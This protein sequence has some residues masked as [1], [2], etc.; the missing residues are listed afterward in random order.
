M[1]TCA[2]RT[3]VTRT[4]PVASATRPGRG[5]TASH[6]LAALALFGATAACS[7]VQHV[8]LRDDYATTD[9]LSTVRIAVVVAPLPGGREDLGQLWATLA[10]RYANQH[11]DFLARPAL[12]AASL[13]AEACAAPRQGVLHLLPT[14]RVDGD[15]VAVTVTASLRRCADDVQIWQAS[16]KGSWA[17]ADDE[18]A[19]MTRTYSE[20][21]GEAV[22]AHVAPTYRLLRAVLAELPE[23]KLTDDQDVMDKIEM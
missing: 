20:E 9:R 13:P 15:E 3:D 23:P 8:E 18:L 12:F 6:A 19:E 2:I 16:G 1:P 17:S 5:W 7:A 21:V 14:A 4:T 11:R 10:A 22:R